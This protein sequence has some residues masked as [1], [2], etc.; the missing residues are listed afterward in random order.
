MPKNASSGYSS[1]ASSR[2]TSWRSQRAISRRQRRSR[3]L[4]RGRVRGERGDHE[5]DE[6]KEE[7]AKGQESET[8]ALPPL[9]GE[10]WLGDRQ[11]IARR[12]SPQAPVRAASGLCPI[13]SLQTG[14]LALGGARLAVMAHG[15]VKAI[16]MAQMVDQRHRRAEHA[17]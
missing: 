1:A 14:P 16:Q 9:L 4:Q 5:E 10:W 2:S 6:A 7:T 13:G 11:V 3:A 15:M 17:S 8:H 12:I